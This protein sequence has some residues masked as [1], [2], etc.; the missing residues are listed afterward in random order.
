MSVKESILDAYRH[1]DKD[2]L[3]WIQSELK[4]NQEVLDKFF[5]EYLDVFSD[6]MSAVEDQK[7]PIWVAYKDK[8]KES[9]DVSANLKLTQY[10]LG[11][12]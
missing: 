8:F 9:Q 7:A 10:Y 11:I 3:I 2:A 1:Q 12:L 5:L 4:Q 6:Q